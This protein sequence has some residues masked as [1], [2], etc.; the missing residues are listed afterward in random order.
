[1]ATTIPNART[2]DEA[3][4]IDGVS[5]HQYGWNVATVG[6]SRYDLPPLRGENIRLAYRPG[7]V[8]RPKVADSRTINL[9]MWVSGADPATG[10]AVNDQRLRWND[11]WDFLRRL[12]WKPHGTQVTLTRRW[13]LTDPATGNPQL[14]V[15]SGLAEIADQMPP[16]MTGRFR[17][18]FAMTL[19]MA[20][21]FFYGPEVEVP[22]V[23]GQPVSVVNPGH[24]VSAH[25]GL[26]V[27]FIGPLINPR[28]TNITADPNTWVQYNGPISTGQSVLCDVGAYQATRLP[29]GANHINLIRHSGAR[30]WMGLLPGT[31]SLSL[32]SGTAATGGYGNARLRY[33]PPYV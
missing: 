25:T 2:T 27:E 19:L 16:T 3:W 4:E 8:H 11:S 20:D 18:D 29:A 28:L 31:N 9:I 7:A 22:L 13:W 26:E 23:R 5:L 15:A 30:H 6:G 10:N 1:M 14:V 12:V 32:T 33:R 17:A 24:D 21:P